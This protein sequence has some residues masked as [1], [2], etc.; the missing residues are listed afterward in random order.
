[1][2]ILKQAFKEIEDRVQVNYSKYNGDSLDFTYYSSMNNWSHSVRLMVQDEKVFLQTYR[3]DAKEDLI[4]YKF[5]DYA[6]NQIGCKIPITEKD[7]IWKVLTK[8]DRFKVKK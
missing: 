4:P 2:S 5:T 3:V 8:Y 1:M 6:H 7:L